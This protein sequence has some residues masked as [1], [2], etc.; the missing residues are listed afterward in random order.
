M[1]NW[2]S[3]T[4][5]LTASKEKV[6]EFQKFL[7]EKN[8]K[9]WFDF[10]RPCP[11]E[12]KDVGNVDPTKTNEQL[13]EKYGYS[14]WYSFGL[15]EWGCKWNCDAQD[16]S[17]NELD[18]DKS[19]ITFWFDSPWG[20]PTSL[21]ENINDPVDLNGWSVYAEWYECGIGFVGYFDEGY[22]N[23]FEFSNEEDLDSIPEFLIENWNIRDDLFSFDN[24][25]E[26][27]F[28]AAAE[29]DEIVENYEED[30]NDK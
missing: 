16:W 5:E 19:V 21:Y 7:D 18:E 14:D 23:N 3:N 20:P 1:P 9:D 25:E 30:E 29:L 10:F 17:V 27:E 24:D 4:I 26:V 8:G 13:I 2:C 22:E 28:D 6:A 12:L 11:Q 15:G